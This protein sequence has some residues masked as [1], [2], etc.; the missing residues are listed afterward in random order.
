MKP[1][2]WTLWLTG[3]PAAGKTTLAYALWERLGQLGIATALLD[4]D[5][6]RRILA[7]ATILTANRYTVSGDDHGDVLRFQAGHWSS[8]HDPISALVDLHGDRLGLL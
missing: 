1:K 5:D 2:G 6:L 7:R 8:Q 4:S 3:L